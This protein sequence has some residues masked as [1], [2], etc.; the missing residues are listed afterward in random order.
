M[1]TRYVAIDTETTGLDSDQDELI[2]VAAIAFDLKNGLGEYN[3]L[4][5]PRQ[6][7]PYQIERLTG[8]EA[9][10]LAS[11]PSVSDI[12]NDLAEFI[13]NSVI[14]GQSI[15]FDINF[16]TRAGISVPGEVVDTWDM[17]QLLLP[18]LANYSLRG[19]A[20]HLGID[21][22]VRHRARADADAARSVFL[23]LRS[24]LELLPLGILQELDR[25]AE[26]G[27]WS[28]G[29]VIREVVAAA[30]AVT[31]APA[32]LTAAVLAQPEE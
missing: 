28:V 15:A 22:P 10:E 32:P 25:L 30:E 16:L 24:R 26:A 2:E 6:K 3:T 7:L 27:E 11:A 13:G 23:A 19:I 14:V 12:A 18:G 31:G 9:A 20:E 4:V 29:V 5:R 8:I 1:T 17:A 21:F